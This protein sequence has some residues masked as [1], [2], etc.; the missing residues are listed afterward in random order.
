MSKNKFYSKILNKVKPYHFN[1]FLIGVHS[2]KERDFKDLKIKLGKKIEKNT[3]KVVDF[4]NPD[5]MIIID[6]EKEKI[7]L[8]IKPA[9]LYGRY[10]KLKR[11]IPQ[12]KWHCRKCRGKGCKECNFTGKKYQTSVQELIENSILSFYKGS[13]LKFHGCGRED[14]DAK[15]LGNGR[16]FVAEIENPKK[17]RVDLNKVQEKT[18]KENEKKVEV[19]NLTYVKKETIQTIKSAR[20]DK[21]YKIKVSFRDKVSK[22]KLKKVLFKLEKDTIKQRTPNRVSHRRSDLIR[23]R[24]VKK[25]NLLNFSPKEADLKI[26]GEAGLYIK[27]LIS[28]DRNRTKPSLTQL[29]KTKAVVEKLDV[30]NVD[31]KL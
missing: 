31:F 26:K 14:I 17:R 8:Q 2:N 18:N 28:G 9:Y 21:T 11:G 6:L 10:K 15:M 29:L 16:P 5:L 3:D 30:T 20:P 27:E 24:E 23:E 12:T 22:E 1:S 13:E 7:N 4:K 25:I 19:N